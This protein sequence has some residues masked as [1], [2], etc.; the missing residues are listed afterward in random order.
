MT[1]S[2][3]HVELDPAGAIDVPA[4]GTLSRTLHADDDLRVVV[5][6]FSEGEELTE[7]TSS[8]TAIVQVLRGELELTLD[9]E[10]ITAREGAW[11][12]MD[13]GLRHAVRARTTAV[14]L[15][16]LVGPARSRPAAG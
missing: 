10:T 1:S 15:L 13:V 5:F 8:R 7:H 11:V 16:T 6:G 2:P 4:A 3:F 14:M 12:H 9:G